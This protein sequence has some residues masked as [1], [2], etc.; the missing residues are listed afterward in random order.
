MEN[1]NKKH[2]NMRL[3]VNTGLFVLISIIFAIMAAFGGNQIHTLAQDEF[4]RDFY[5]S[6]P[7][8][9]FGTADC[10]YLEEKDELKEAE[11]E[12][13]KVLFYPEFTLEDYNI[14]MMGEEWWTTGEG[15]PEYNTV[16]I[17]YPCSAEILTNGKNTS[18]IFA[19]IVALEHELF[20]E[21]RYI[22][23]FSFGTLSIVSLIAAAIYWNH[24]RK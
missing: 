12:D 17:Y 16:S 23:M 21:N 10:Y 6:V 24:N 18:S 4:I 14:A 11:T 1:Q 9:A 8:Q 22:I 5:S 15:D 19:R 2:H 7:A 20:P 13:Y 3:A